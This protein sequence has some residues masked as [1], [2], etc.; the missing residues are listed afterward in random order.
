MA[1]EDAF[2][3]SCS[4]CR[5]WASFW[6]KGYLMELKFLVLAHPVGKKKKKKEQRFTCKLDEK[7]HL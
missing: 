4:R 7:K 2:A 6:K 1:P 5:K 3:V